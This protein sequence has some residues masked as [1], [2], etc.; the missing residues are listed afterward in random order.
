MADLTGEPPVMWGPSMIGFGRYQYTYESGHSGE[1]FRVGFAVRGAKTAIYIIP[2]LDRYAALLDGLGPHKAAKSCL[3]VGALKTLDL[4]TL[5]TLIAQSLA[6][7][8]A[9]YG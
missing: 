6:D 8:R 2:G 3:Y 9:K 5:R 1:S 7:I 4:A